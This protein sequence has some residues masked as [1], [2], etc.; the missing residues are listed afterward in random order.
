MPKKPPRCQQCHRPGTTRE[1]FYAGIGV[2]ERCNMLDEIDRLRSRG[3]EI[4][5]QNLDLNRTVDML[6]AKLRDAEL[7]AATLELTINSMTAKINFAPLAAALAHRPDL[8]AR[9][10]SAV[11][12]GISVTDRR[13]PAPKTRP[14]GET[15]GEKGKAP[16]Q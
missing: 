10:S 6:S 13:K 14:E 1:Y 9:L 2:C 7:D 4:S 8:F 3:S 5:A 11:Q 16:I 15:P 12:E